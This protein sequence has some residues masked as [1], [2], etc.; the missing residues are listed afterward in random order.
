[1]RVQAQCNLFLQSFVQWDYGCDVPYTGGIRLFDAAIVES[2]SRL[3]PRRD[4]FHRMTP[5][6]SMLS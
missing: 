4:A 5:L 1:M 2:L 6:G 3:Q